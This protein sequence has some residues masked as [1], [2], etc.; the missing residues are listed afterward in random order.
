LNFITPVHLF[1]TADALGRS[2]VETRTVLVRTWASLA[3]SERCLRR[4]VEALAVSRE[5]LSATTYVPGSGL[6]R[7]RP[8]D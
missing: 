6:P 4:S 7:A 8:R 3:L 1:D 2:G 5:L